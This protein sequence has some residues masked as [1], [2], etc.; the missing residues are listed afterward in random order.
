MPTWQHR[1]KILNKEQRAEL[2]Q[3]RQ[4]MQGRDKAVMRKAIN[5][6]EHLESI[7]IDIHYLIY[8]GPSGDEG[9]NS[10]ERDEPRTAPWIPWRLG[11]KGDGLV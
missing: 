9:E 2:H 8:K 10:L 6:I 11:G 4:R 1:L 3:V 7:I 5:H